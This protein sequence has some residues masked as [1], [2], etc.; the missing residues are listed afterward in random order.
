MTTADHGACYVIQT[1][2]RD[3]DAWT[4]KVFVMTEQDAWHIMELV[5]RNT[6]H[7]CRWLRTTEKALRAKR[8]RIELFPVHN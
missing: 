1:R 4:D 6:F 8:K 7:Q 5:E 3:T 2:R